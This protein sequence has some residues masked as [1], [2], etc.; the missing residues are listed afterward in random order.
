[1]AVSRL[2]MINVPKFKNEWKI[3]LEKYLIFGV[4]MLGINL[5]QYYFAYT[6]QASWWVN[7]NV[8]AIC[9]WTV[10]TMAV[11]SPYF[12][13][14]AFPYLKISLKLAKFR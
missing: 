8:E 3:F 12:Y 7:Q 9:E 2:K 1:M 6:S 4:T 13:S 10:I 14:L 11:F 5:Y